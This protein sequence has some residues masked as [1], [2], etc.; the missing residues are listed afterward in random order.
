MSND[1]GLGA[2]Q[3]DLRS[4]EVDNDIIKP[5]FRLEGNELPIHDT[6]TI[7]FIS[8]IQYKGSVELFRDFRG[9]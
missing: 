8:F 9:S 5:L 2:L 3:L 4:T 7:V 6:R 1:I